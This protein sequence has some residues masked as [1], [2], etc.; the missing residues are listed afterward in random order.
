MNQREI[1][2]RVAAFEEGKRVRVEQLATALL[3]ELAGMAAMD[4]LRTLDKSASRVRGLA[5]GLRPR[6]PSV[7][8]PIYLAKL[9]GDIFKGLRNPIL[10]RRA[11]CRAEV[12]F[13]IDAHVRSSSEKS[14]YATGV[15]YPRHKA[16]HNNQE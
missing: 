9:V 16:G 14:L 11:L 2:G 12:A 15:K 6:R 5:C 7:E 4:E 3:N 8:L 13:H 10:R 1:A